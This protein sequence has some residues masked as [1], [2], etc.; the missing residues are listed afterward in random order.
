VRIVGK[1]LFPAEVHAAFD[2]G[3]WLTPQ[4]FDAATPVQGPDA[5][6]ALERLVVVRFRNGVDDKAATR[7]LSKTLSTRA[8][9]GAVDVPVELANLRNVHRLPS[10][11][12]G[13]L[14]LLAVAAVGH[15]L[16]TSVRRRRQDF[17]VLR[18]LGITRWGV[19]GILNA[20]GSAIGV[21]GLLLGIPLGLAVGRV[22]WQAVTDRVPLRYV[23]PVGLLVL[24]AIVPLVIAAANLL[25]VW[26][27][28]RAARLRP[29]EVLR[30]E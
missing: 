22:G 11:L 29:A 3:A 5:E 27:G 20:Q 28:R 7:H 16:A 8:D 30:T 1:A 2:E 9:V 14:A 15:V 10:L 21:T 23:S 26:P 12:A 13:F 19:R 18:A 25:A 6:S 4:T 24:A 17:A